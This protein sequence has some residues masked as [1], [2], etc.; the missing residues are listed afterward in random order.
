MSI[1]SD[2]QEGSII[3]CLGMDVDEVE[4]GDEFAVTGCPA[5]VTV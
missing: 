2:P 3:Q 4:A 5:G 1:C